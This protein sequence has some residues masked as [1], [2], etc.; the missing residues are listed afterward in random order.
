M[1][2]SPSNCP[3]TQ[4]LDIKMKFVAQYPGVQLRYLAEAVFIDG[5]VCA[6]DFEDLRSKFTATTWHNG[7]KVNQ[8]DVHVCVSRSIV[9]TV[10]DKKERWEGTTKPLPRTTENLIVW[11]LGRRLYLCQGYKQV[12]GQAPTDITRP[13][14]HDCFPREHHEQ[15]AENDLRAADLQ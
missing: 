2:H 1:Q 12:T 3:S 11:V 5:A 13:R 6:N 8:T 4:V 15:Q 10:L 7:G 14:H 9:C